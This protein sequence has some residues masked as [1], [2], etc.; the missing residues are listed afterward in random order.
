MVLVK[1]TTDTGAVGWGE[2][3][4]TLMTLPVRESVREVA[5]FYTGKE[6]HD[7]ARNFS[8]FC[9]YS[10]YHSRSIEATFRRL[11]CPRAR[12]YGHGHAHISCYCGEQ[13][14]D[15]ESDCRSPTGSC[16]KVDEA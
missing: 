15:H 3:P 2:A 1:V 9:R 10:F 14:P 8:E 4:T 7:S 11:G 12:P 5:R 6:L 16:G 13:S